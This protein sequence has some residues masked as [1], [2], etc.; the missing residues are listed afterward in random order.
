[1]V[2]VSITK[3]NQIVQSVLQNIQGTTVAF[4]KHTMA[5]QLKAVA[6]T[7]AK[8]QCGVTMLDCENN[9]IHIDGTK[10]N[11]EN[12]TSCEHHNWQ[13]TKFITWF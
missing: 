12:L 5:T 3:C 13:K 11:T 8:I 4:P 6:G 10:R 2:A 7:L 9:T 1:M